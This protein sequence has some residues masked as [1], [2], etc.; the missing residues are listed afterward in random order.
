[1]CVSCIPNVALKTT[2]EPYFTTNGR[3]HYQF[4]PGRCLPALAIEARSDTPL[5]DKDRCATDFMIRDA[6]LGEVG[7][8]PATE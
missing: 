3:G 8:L 7:G 6:A 1:M 4:Q 5:I 2:A